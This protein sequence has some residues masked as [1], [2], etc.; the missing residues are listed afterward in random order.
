MKKLGNLNGNFEYELLDENQQDSYL[1]QKLA[2]LYSTPFTDILWWELKK[3]S[4][5]ENGCYKLY[6]YE[7]TGLKHIILFQHYVKAPQ[8]IVV[9]N[10]EFKISSKHIENIAS[11]LFNEFDR[12]QQIIFEKIFEHDF[13]RLPKMIFEKTWHNDV[14]IPLPKFMD[15]YMKS[16]GSSTHKKIKL[17]TNRIAKDF[18]DFKVRFFEKN[19]ILFEHIDRVLSLNNERMKIKGIDSNT[20]LESKLY[21]YTSTS[22]YGLLCLCEINGKMAGTTFGFIFG[23]HAY[24][25]K[26]AHDNA[27]NKYSLGQIALIHTTKYLIEEKKIKHYHLLGGAQEY[28]YHHGGVNFFL[29]TVKVFRNNDVYYFFGKKIAPLV[30]KYWEFRRRLKKNK[31]IFNFYNKLYFLK[32]KLKSV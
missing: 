19:E 20:H 5:K 21:Q 14:I 26:I 23:E 8:K 2:N 28:K 4:L 27:Y 16:L 3:S 6:Y 18:P 12:V 25:Y 17:M 10:K 22:G 30:T 1:R 7:Q 31:T 9:V 24:L 13:Q 11:I 32:M 15:D 29:Y